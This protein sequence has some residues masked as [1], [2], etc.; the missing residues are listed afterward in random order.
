MFIACNSIYH[1]TCKRYVP[2]FCGVPPDILSMLRIQTES[3][4][5][6]QQELKEFVKKTLPPLEIL[7]IVVK[8]TKQEQSLPSGSSYTMSDFV[9]VSLLGKGNFGKVYLARDKKH[10]GRLIALKILQKSYILEHDEAD[11]LENEKKVFTKIAN[12]HPFLIHMYGCFQTKD[13]VVFVIEYV[14]GGDLMHHIQLGSFGLEQAK[15]Y[16]AQILLALEHLHNEHDVIYRDLKL[17]NIL[18]CSDGYIK[19]ADYGL[20]KHGMKWDTTTG[21]FC[22]T[23]EFMAPEVIKGEKYTKSVDWWA[24]GVLLYELLL[25]SSPFFGKNE[26]EIFQSILKCNPVYP[27]N[28]DLNATSLMKKLLVLDPKQRMGY[29]KEG[30]KQIKAHPFYHDI[31][32]DLLYKK[33]S[34]LNRFLVPKITSEADV[35]N[36]DKE[37]TREA[38]DFVQEKDDKDDGPVIAAA[39]DMEKKPENDC[40]KDFDCI[41]YSTGH[42]KSMS[43]KNDNYIVKQHTFH[44][45]SK[46]TPFSFN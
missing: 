20:C 3:A 22:G 30:S 1:D 11:S 15:F 21:T 35:C 33:E 41:V 16:S 43:V 31:N 14:P 37:F 12:K 28:L 40:F 29:G 38:I 7:P 39:L 42:I 13:L 36:F 8:N 25:S 5:N 24:F 46:S 17:D 9:L 4:N 18:L 2:P 23:P 44:R 6:V 10:N 19:L 45:S 26:E 27:W 32:F 34:R